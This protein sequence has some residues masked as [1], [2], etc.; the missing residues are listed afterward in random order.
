MA[1]GD[2]GGD[3][4]NTVAFSITNISGPGVTLDSWTMTVG[5]TQ[6]LYDFLYL[7]KEQFLGGDGSQTVML[8]QGE[9]DLDDGL[10]TDSFAYAF[11]NLGPGVGFA[12]QWDIDFDNG[13]FNVDARAVLFNNGD[14]PNAVAT[15]SFSDGSVAQYT[16]PDLPVQETYSLTIPAPG[17][18]PIAGLGLL[19]ALR[20]RRA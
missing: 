16:F 10:G 11:T 9:H 7:N 1:G 20:R 2:G 19:A 12:G 17:C 5:D 3:P 6:F 8:T 14:A 13:A 18:I 15:F 4:F